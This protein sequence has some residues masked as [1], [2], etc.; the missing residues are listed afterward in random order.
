MENQDIQK[1]PAQKLKK[2]TNY[3]EEVSSSENSSSSE[4]ESESESESSD[5]SSSD[6][7]RV[8]YGLKKK[9]LL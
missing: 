8:C 3:V 7:N 5:S 1:V 6:E 2:K 9:V 4:S